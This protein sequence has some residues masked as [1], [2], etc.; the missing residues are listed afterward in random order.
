MHTPQ[1][2]RGTRCVYRRPV[3]FLRLSPGVNSQQQQGDRNFV[4]IAA[5]VFLENVQDLLLVVR[6]FSHAHLSWP[7]SGRWLL[8][9]SPGRSP[10]EHHQ[11]RPASHP[12]FIPP[13]TAFPPIPPPPPP[14]SLP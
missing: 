3:P 5:R 8:T 11:R 6:F 14:P 1:P 7:S 13:P 12:H 4:P 10:V 9:S 2:N